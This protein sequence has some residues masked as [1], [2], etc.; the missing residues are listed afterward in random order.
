MRI[1][2]LALVLAF[3][4]VQT[5]EPPEYAVGTMCTP[6]GDN[7]N[8]LQTPDHPCACKNMT[9]PTPDGECDLLITN[10]SLCKQWCHEKHCSCPRMCKEPAK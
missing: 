5:Q 6:A 3:Q 7:V 10:D 1:L 9:A 8:G 4:V 2:L